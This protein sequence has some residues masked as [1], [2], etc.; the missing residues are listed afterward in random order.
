VGI[1]GCA[2]HCV[3]DTV[4]W[5]GSGRIGA[6]DFVFFFVFFFFFFSLVLFLI[7]LLLALI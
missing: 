6:S 2:E 5:D 7:V 3:D 1:L 4:G